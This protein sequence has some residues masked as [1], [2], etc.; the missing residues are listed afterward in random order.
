M[1]F[2]GRR[3]NNAPQEGS[4]RSAL[5]LS[6]ETRPVGTR[7]STGT[8]SRPSTPLASRRRTPRS[9]TCSSPASGAAP[10]PAL[11][12]RRGHVCAGSDAP[13]S[14]PRLNRFGIPAVAFFGAPWMPLFPRWQI[15]ASHLSARTVA[16]HLCYHHC[17]ASAAADPRP[18]R[19]PGPFRD[20]PLP[21][22]PLGTA[23][24]ASRHQAKRADRVVHR[25]AAAAPKA[26]EADSRGGGA[27][28][29]AC[30]SSAA[31][32]LRAPSNPPPSRHLSRPPA[33]RHTL[34]PPVS[35][36]EQMARRLPRRASGPLRQAQGRVRQ[37]R[38]QAGDLV[39]CADAPVRHGSSSQT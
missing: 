30:R 39:N 18:P 21:Q 8:P 29:T 2:R 36:G 4:C 37:A 5:P 20:R 23:L 10:R 35:A 6:L 19:T 13:R 32:L 34:A 1:C 24:A 38:R 33:T 17:A 22:R 26:R 16:S 3:R 27:P 9:R 15:A 14:S 12:P 7:C 11:S 25:A 28:A 31:P